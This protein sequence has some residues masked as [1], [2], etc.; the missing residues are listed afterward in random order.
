[1]VRLRPLAT[2]LAVAALLLD[3]APAWAH[4]FPDHAQ[5]AVGSTVSPAP[6]E[7][8]IW[9][10]QKLEPAFSKVEVRDASGA[11]VDKDDATVGPEDASVLHVSLKALPAGTYKVSWRAVSVDTHPTEGDFTFTVK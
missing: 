6:T 1:M 9:F 11:R 7:L 4:A 5:P 2:A 8:R 10:T 3:T